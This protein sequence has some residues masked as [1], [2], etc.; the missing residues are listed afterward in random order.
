[1]IMCCI[2]DCKEEG[3]VFQM[4][5]G[6]WY[7]IDHAWSD[8]R[9]NEDGTVSETT[10]VKP[11]AKTVDEKYSIPEKKSLN[12]VGSRFMHLAE[13]QDYFEDGL[14]AVC[15]S[16]SRYQ[17]DIDLKRKVRL[18]GAI[19]LLKIYEEQL[20]GYATQKWAFNKL[21]DECVPTKEALSAIKA[22]RTGRR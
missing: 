9:V 21:L 4:A 20:A 22:D 1:M 2:P 3:M 6:R 14:I 15:M 7:C 18:E 12:D 17:N 16:L 10:E 19:L 13:L 8:D 5:T 11:E